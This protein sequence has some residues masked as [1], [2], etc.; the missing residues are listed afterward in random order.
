MPV[1]EKS[2]GSADVLVG[3]DGWKMAD[4]NVGAPTGV[5]TLGKAGVQLINTA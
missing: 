3:I 2:A 1:T 4:E 5:V